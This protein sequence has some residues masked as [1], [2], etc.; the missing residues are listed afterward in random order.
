MKITTNE[1]S[2]KLNISRRAVQ[3]IINSLKEKNVLTREG[4]RKIGYML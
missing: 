4:S 1:L 2:E 3:T